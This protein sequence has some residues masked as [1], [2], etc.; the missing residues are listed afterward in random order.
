MQN[1][2][3]DAL[4]CPINVS[5]KETKKFLAHREQ[6]KEVHFLQRKYPIFFMSGH[7]SS[8]MEQIMMPITLIK[9]V[10][11]NLTITKPTRL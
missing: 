2:K 10:P 9:C 6:R 7:L 3:A 5:K 4:Q 8:I 11:S 1:T